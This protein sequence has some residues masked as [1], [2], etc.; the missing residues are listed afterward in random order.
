MSGQSTIDTV[1]PAT[2][3]LLSFHLAGR[4]GEKLRWRTVGSQRWP[5]LLRRYYDLASI[6]HN[7]PLILVDRGSCRGIESLTDVINGLL[8]RVAPRGTEGEKMRRHV[9][10]LEKEIR[11]MVYRK[12][13]GALSRLWSAAAANLTAQTDLSAEERLTLHE[14]LEDAQSKLDVEG[15]VIGCG[16]DTADCVMRHLW[17]RTHGARV[18]RTASQLR[19]LAI[20]LNDL[21]RSDDLE[22]ADSREPAA[23]QR[24][25]GAHFK[26]LIDFRA[27]ASTLSGSRTHARMPGK[28]RERIEWALDVL[29]AEKFFGVE[30]ENKRYEFVFASCK[31]ALAEFG[32]RLPRMVDLIKAIRIAGLE[33]ENRYREEIH[34]DI[35]KNIDAGSLTADDI[36]WF[37]SYLVSLRERD[38]DAENRAE[39][40]ELLSSE[41]PIKLIFQVD[42]LFHDAKGRPDNFGTAA[43]RT[44][45]A[46]MAVNLGS[47]FVLQ[48][49]TS[50]L[51]PMAERLADGLANQKP[52]LFSLFSPGEDFALPA[53][54][55]AAAAIESRL[56]PTIVFDPEKG[57]AWAECFSLDGNPQPEKD[58]P[59]HTFNY[60]DDEMQVCTENLPFTPVDFLAADPGF[61]EG[62]QAV[63]RNEWSEEMIPVADY[64]QADA[65]QNYGRVPF[66]LMVGQNDRLERVA[67]TSVAVQLV[68]QVARRWHNLQ[69]LGGIN[70]SHARRALDAASRTWESEKQKLM[71]EGR[72]ATSMNPAEPLEQESTAPAASELAESAKVEPAPAASSDEA[73]IETPRCTSCNECIN[74]NPR[75]FKYNDNKQAFLADLHAGSYRDLV[76]AA[77]SCKVAIIHP[78]KPWNPNEPGLEE[79]LQRAEPFR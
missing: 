21:L 16:A 7:Y 58:W 45:L 70:N 40:I 49:A 73:W 30:A 32:N 9:L 1:S 26:E 69:E 20:R 19:E 57:D 17:R 35:F 61:A 23:L 11:S 31:G 65:A 62:L 66:V 24:A 2:R 29:R 39:L 67:V 71:E 27:M 75:M 54:L 25:F 14:D 22:S 47:A 52:A 64:L 55:T 15:E 74:R 72:A 18:A 59:I 6:R 8:Q 77:E 12:E 51:C 63:P 5:A 33:L 50:N 34:D 53:Y 13:S 43:W 28:R 38:C 41:L 36:R 3:K 79:L 10:R 56:F 37:P 48:T 4:S 60:E 42:H 78:G 76:E 46:S 44:Q 68:R